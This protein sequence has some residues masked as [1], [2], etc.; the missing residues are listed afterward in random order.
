M[1]KEPRSLT[2]AAFAPAVSIHTK[3]DS[4][5]P[6]KNSWTRVYLAAPTRT[7]RQRAA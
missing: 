2:V 5:E 7:K 4:G 1:S 6:R 3:R